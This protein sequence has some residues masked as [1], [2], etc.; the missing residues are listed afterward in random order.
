MSIGQFLFDVRTIANLL[1]SQEPGV[2]HARSKY[3]GRLGFFREARRRG[4]TGLWANVLDDHLGVLEP[5]VVLPGSKHAADEAAVDPEGR[6]VD[7]GGERAAQ[8]GNEVRDLF[9]IDEPLNE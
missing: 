9:R 6:A 1:R 4:S 8:V 2:F 3:P 5:S 7:G